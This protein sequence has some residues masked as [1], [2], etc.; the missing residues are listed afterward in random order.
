M[1]LETSH[2]LC[3]DRRYKIF[4]W[5]INVFF[6][7]ETWLGFKVSFWQSQMMLDSRSS[8]A[9]INQLFLHGTS[10]LVPDCIFNCILYA[11]AELQRCSAAVH[12]SD[13]RHWP[14]HWSC[15]LSCGTMVTGD[16]R[17][18]AV[19]R[20]LHCGLW[21][22]TNIYRSY[23]IIYFSSQNL[24]ALNLPSPHWQ[25]VK[26][27]W[28]QTLQTSEERQHF[29]HTFEHFYTT[30]QTVRHFS[31]FPKIHSGLLTFQSPFQI[32]INHQC[33]FSKSMRV[34]HIEQC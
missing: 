6:R 5:E 9:S 34:I 19:T 18:H 26:V 25:C 33:P 27:C 28:R 14:G 13:M 20:Y 3:C 10:G 1:L 7:L 17:T 12:D 22:D 30:I 15:H 8:V 16:T 4:S 32:H 23:N 21:V 29:G 2:S 24:M 31:L 11:R